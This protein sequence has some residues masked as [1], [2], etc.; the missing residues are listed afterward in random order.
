MT[1]RTGANGCVNTLGRAPE[2]ER[3]DQEVNIG[4][5]QSRLKF[6]KFTS[7]FTS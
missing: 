7:K 3:Q 4:V 1:M 2:C 5:H 6:T